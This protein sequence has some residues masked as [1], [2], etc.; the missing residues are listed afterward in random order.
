[1]KKLILVD[2]FSLVFRAYYATAY[3][4]TIMR[5]S[6]GFP[7]NSLF[8][9]GSML[10]KLLKE[11]FSHF[12]VAFDADKPTF[13]HVEYPEYKAGRSE[14]PDELKQQ[15][16]FAKEYC[17]KLGI[18]RYELDSYEADDII[19]TLARKA[20]DEGYFVD[21]YTGDK[22][23]LQLASSKITVKIT[24]KG[25]STIEN[26]TP[27]YLKEKISLSPEQVTDLKGLMGD[28]SDNLPGIPG[29]GEKTA[30]KLLLEYGNIENVI[31]DMDNIKGKL[32]ER[33]REHYEQGLLCKKLATIKEDTPIEISLEDTLYN[34][35]DEDVLNEFYRELE[36][37]SFIKKKPKPI[38]E[39]KIITEDEIYDIDKYL[40]GNSFISVE[41]Y[42]DNY[43][44]SQILGL[45]IL[46]ED[47]IFIPFELVQNNLTSVPD[48]LADEKRE[49]YT[50]DLK[51]VKVAL[52]WLGYD[53]KG[54]KFDC[55]LASYIINP[56]NK[57]ELK[58]I[59]R[60]YHYDD[61]Q[62]KEEVFGKGKSKVIPEIKKLASYSAKRAHAIKFLMEDLVKE[63]KSTSQYELF[64][65]ELE[66]ANVLA[67]MEFDGVLIDKLELDN[68]KEIYKL[69]I[70]KLS[71]EIFEIV[72]KE[73]NINSPKQLG[74]ILFEDLGLPS[75]KKTKTGF[76]T[77]VDALKGLKAM[78]PV[79]DKILD[80]RT[81]QK[82]LSTYLEGIEKVLYNEKVHTI[83]KQATT[84]TGRLS[85]IEPNLQNLPIKT[86]EG[87]NIR[88]LFVPTPGNMLFA[89]DYSQIELR[90][91]AHLAESDT[92]KY[93]FNNDLD[94]HTETAM[95]VFGV[96][97]QDI[98]SKM[99]RQAKAVNFGIIYGQG[100]WGLSTEIDTSVTEAERFINEYFRQFPTIKDFLENVVI[101]AKETGFVETLLNRRRYLPDINS[102]NYN[103]RSFAERTAKNAPI[104][105]S[106]ADIIKL[107][108]VDIYKEIKKRKLRTRLI[109][110]IHDE[111][112]FDVPAEEIKIIEKIVPE[113]M[114]NALKLDV[115]LKVDYGFG[116]N[117]YEVK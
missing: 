90:V 67:D 107:A 27:A 21:V 81:N 18:K 42:E 55:L 77:D 117:M 33:I 8:A 54:V 106:A 37:F 69:K 65:L 98:T 97:K 112:V 70:E 30:T 46:N 103:I 48:W 32:G 113:V 62:S 91:L 108:M 28:S 94:I 51:A 44:K 11:D 72:G 95:K 38:T 29:V 64:K 100:A 2:G 45:T 111:L 3:T 110:Q 15:I 71:K 109:I 101:K 49:K 86:E 34:G 52:K 40:K 10:S 1:M 104:Q 47:E 50:F 41:I 92:L 85:S 115:P 7:T 43:H 102:S 105:G 96:D 87:R 83:F 14:T 60:I 75:S 23:L 53:L 24:K 59:A 66:L 63:L 17:D 93:A 99:R 16:P 78:H 88:K 6:K 57:E 76:S 73:F 12:L 25:I 68:Q 9:F 22:D 79:V 56:S 39:I 26:Y 89:A 82:L 36:F 61:V 5:N 84:A 35:Y 58:D 116:K 19:G 4:G 20:A 80:F 13:R 31:K 74:S 114:E